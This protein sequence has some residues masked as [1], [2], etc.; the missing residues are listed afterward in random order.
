VSDTAEAYVS[1]LRTYPDGRKLVASEKAVLAYVAKS[2]HNEL[3]IAWIGIPLL[4]VR[5]CMSERT[6]QRHLRKLAAGGLIAVERSYRE[7]GGGQSSNH[8]SF[9]LLALPTEV[10]PE[11]QAAARAQWQTVRRTTKATPVTRLS[12]PPPGD[13]RVT[14]S[15]SALSPAPV[16]TVSPLDL[17]F[18]LP[19]KVKPR[20]SRSAS[21]YRSHRTT[22]NQAQL[23]HR[24]PSNQQPSTPP[25]PPER[26]M[27]LADA[28]AS[29]QR[30]AVPLDDALST[31]WVHGVEA[32]VVIAV[33]TRAAHAAWI[34]HQQSIRNAWRIQYGWTPTFSIT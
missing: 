12:P 34:I 21:S 4:A 9:P 30:I 7:K 20:A 15:P 13:N 6:A 17:H 28:R 18:D 14:P 1:S 26:E 27:T 25:R 23:I 5:A 32:G 2:H 29:W 8:Y 24:E 16:T 10:S 33:S 22:A 19:P 3:G 31:V 11:M